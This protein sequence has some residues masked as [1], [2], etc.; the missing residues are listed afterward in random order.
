LEADRD[1]ELWAVLPILSIASLVAYSM[2]GAI[3]ISTSGKV[4][5]LRWHV[6]SQFD[7]I[8][9]VPRIDTYGIDESNVDEATINAS[10]GI[11]LE[12]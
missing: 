5:G 7:A 2:R 11:P 12:G 9:K 4:I 10:I 8:Y 6:P 3:G 1:P